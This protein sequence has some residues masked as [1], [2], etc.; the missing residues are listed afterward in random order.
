MN[1]FQHI[2][3]TYACVLL[4]GGM[5]G[6]ILSGSVISLATSAGSFCLLALLVRQKSERTALALMGM[7]AMFFL[8]RFCHTLKIFPAGMMF[9]LTALAIALCLIAHDSESASS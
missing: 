7:L 4:L 9:L 3:L 5:L 8:Y 1:R 6:W 2:T